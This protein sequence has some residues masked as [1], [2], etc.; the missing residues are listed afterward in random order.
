MRYL[1][2]GNVRRLLL[3]WRHV[4]HDV[5]L[6]RDQVLLEQK[7]YSV[8]ALAEDGES[9]IKCECWTFHVQLPRVPDTNVG[10]PHLFFE[11]FIK[12]HAC[13][14]DDWLVCWRSGVFLEYFVTA[15]LPILKRRTSTRSVRHTS[16]RVACHLP[17]TGCRNGRTTTLMYRIERARNK[18]SR[19]RVWW[20]W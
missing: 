15:N 5:K 2:R 17:K 9:F 20:W 12:V 14:L 13:M 4:I 8:I 19:E 1:R 6:C 7:F 18:V 3:V 11:R 16:T 10:H